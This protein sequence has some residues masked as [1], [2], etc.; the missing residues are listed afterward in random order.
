M[1]YT[2][3]EESGF[4]MS[5]YP[6]LM[7]FRG[8]DGDVFAYV[9]N[10]EERNLACLIRIRQLSSVLWYQ[11]PDDIE[12]DFQE[13]LDRIDARLDELG[14]EDIS[15][16][17]L[18]ALP[19]KVRKMINETVYKE[20]AIRKQIDLEKSLLLKQAHDIE[21]LA[22]LPLAEAVQLTTTLPES[23]QVVNL[24]YHIMSSL[25]EDE[26]DGFVEETL[27]VLKK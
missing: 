27:M 10:E 20:L 17:V 13:E 11:T 19:E 6:K 2:P 25:A 8:P 1:V 26:Y 4:D 14:Y 22:N 9:T 15:E 16:S 18:E 5:S 12:E 23:D 21:Q 7:R 3:Y 24:A